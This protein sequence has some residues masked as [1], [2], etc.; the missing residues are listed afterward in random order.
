MFCYSLQLTDCDFLLLQYHRNFSLLAEGT[1][2]WAWRRLLLKL[3]WLWVKDKWNSPLTGGRRPR[4]TSEKAFQLSLSDSSC[5]SALLPPQN[6]PPTKLPSADTQTETKFLLVFVS[7]SSPCS[8]APV[9]G[10]A[11]LWQISQKEGFS[12]PNRQ[13]GSQ[14][15]HLCSYSSN[16]AADGLSKSFKKILFG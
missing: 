10:A 16:N 8:L 9:M 2:G 14:N 11:Y 5:V 6:S 1:G 13:F 3:L 4:H 7:L 12:D 15:L